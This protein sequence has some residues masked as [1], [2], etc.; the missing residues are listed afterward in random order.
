[1]TRKHFKAIAATL[2]EIRDTTDRKKAALNFC[3][4]AKRAN[5]RFD[6]QKFLTACGLSD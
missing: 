2:A 4:I 3:E 6:R 1:M 5:P